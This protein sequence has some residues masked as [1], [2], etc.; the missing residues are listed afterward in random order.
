MSLYRRYFTPEEIALLDA[1]PSDDLTSEIHLLRLLLAR[2]LEAAQRLRQSALEQHAAILGAV[3]AAGSTLAAL[4]RL[5]I[6][7]HD[8]LDEVWAEIQRGKEIGRQRRHVHDYFSQ[9]APA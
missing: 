6:K 1:T 2:L 9:P 8:P 5:Q 7:L 4:L 3:C